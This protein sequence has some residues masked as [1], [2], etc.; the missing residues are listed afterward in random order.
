MKVGLREG[1][2]CA[3]VRSGSAGQHAILGVFGGDFVEAD[4]GLEHEQHVEAV[5]ADV[6]DYAGDLVALDDRLVDCF[7]QL[8]NE[9]TQTRCQGYL[10]GRRQAPGRKAS[11]GGV[12][13]FNL[14]SN[15]TQEQPADGERLSK[16]GDGSHTVTIES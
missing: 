7:A 16:S 13:F 8:L 11:A 15:A 6:L 12:G 9:F 5:L 3:F 2:V 14:T 4:G 1:A 10:Q